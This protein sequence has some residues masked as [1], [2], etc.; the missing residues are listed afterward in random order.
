[1]GTKDIITGHEA[2]IPQPTEAGP[3]LRLQRPC[4]VRDGVNKG[5]QRHDVETWTRTEV[6]KCVLEFVDELYEVLV[7]DVH[8]SSLN[9]SGGMLGEMKERLR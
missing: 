6:T 4:I 7:H 8:L 2:C 1:M 5:R 9:D 3:A